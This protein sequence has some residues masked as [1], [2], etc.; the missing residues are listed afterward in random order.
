MPRASFL[1]TWFVLAA[2][3]TYAG[4]SP[5]NL[6]LGLP[7]DQTVPL[8]LDGY[9]LVSLDRT[10]EVTFVFDDGRKVTADVPIFIYLPERDHAG[11]FKEGLQAIHKQ[12]G[13]LASQ[14]QPVD[15]AQLMTIFLALDRLLATGDLPTVKSP[16]ASPQQSRGPSPEVGGKPANPFERAKQSQSADR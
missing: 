3:A 4:E 5:R 16:E 14:R 9:R 7:A 13:A 12:L 6:P 2:I 8:K 1:F 11:E 15:S 10:K